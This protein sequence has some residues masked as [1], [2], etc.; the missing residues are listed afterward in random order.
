MSDLVEVGNHQLRTSTTGDVHAGRPL[1][2]VNGIGATMD[3]F[4]PLRAELGDRATIA[5]DAPGVGGSTTPLLP[6]PMGALADVVAAVLDQYGTS[7]TR[8]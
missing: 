1:L 8:V 4:E 6:L 2:L 5:F 7:M 3:L